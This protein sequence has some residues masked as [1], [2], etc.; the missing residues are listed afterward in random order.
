M[1]EREIQKPKQKK[2][3]ILFISV[4]LAFLHNLGPMT[5]AKASTIF[6]CMDEF[7]RFGKVKDALTA[8]R[9]VALAL[10]SFVPLN[11]LILGYHRNRLAPN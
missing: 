11:A 4:D 9:S 6:C 8:S 3:F 10:N 5:K 2:Y 1:R 7:S